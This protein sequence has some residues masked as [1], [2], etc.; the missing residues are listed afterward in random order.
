MY[1]KP[2]VERFGSF[3]ELTQVGW[4]RDSDGLVFLGIGGSNIKPPK[5]ETR[6]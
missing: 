2:E 4:S 6:S 3:R 5:N 1:K